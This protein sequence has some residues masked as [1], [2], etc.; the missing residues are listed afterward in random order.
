MI[1][2]E[3]KLF[4]IIIIFIVFIST[5][6]IIGNL[7]FSFPLNVNYKWLVLIFFSI[8]TFW[9]YFK[10]NK[11]N[12]KFYFF[13]F[14]LVIILPFG[15]ID[16]GGSANNSISYIF[17]YLITISFLIK[18]EKRT[19]LVIILLF[20]IIALIHIEHYFPEIIRVHNQ[21]SQFLDRVFQTTLL[22]TFSYLILQTFSNEYYKEKEALKKLASTDKLTGLY[23]RRYFENFFI[24]EIENN[25]EKEKFLI[26]ID[27]D[28]F[29]VINDTYGHQ[30]GDKVLI[31]I[32][33][34]LKTTFNNS[35][36]SRWGGDEFVVIYNGKKDDLIKKM[37]LVLKK[38]LEI[39]LADS[40]Q[41]TLSS[42]VTKINKND[43]RKLI[44]KKADNAL[45]ISK[46]NGKNQYNF[47]NE[48]TT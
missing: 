10:C 6:S 24:Q 27:I 22:I 25:F 36:I 4:K 42:G 20:E 3:D 48:I 14:I 43:N 47:I 5:M 46:E 21:R 9:K 31:E 2:L 32:S 44:F 18:K 23:N 40:H 7:L 17:L 45:Y 15:W 41:I 34:I 1:Q 16:S 11:S 33:N 12:Y 30:I 39:K 8:I 28:K 38:S 13:F 19:I 35:K 26:I 37:D 29:K